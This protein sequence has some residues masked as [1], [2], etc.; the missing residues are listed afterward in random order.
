MLHDYAWASFG[1]QGW[2]HLKLL[3]VAL[4]VGYH[5]VCGI[6]LQDFKH[7]QNRRSHV[8]YRWANEVPVLFLF[9]IILLASLKPF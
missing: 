1:Q 6:W 7:D 8:F 3:L 9:A 4:L 5:V 2:L